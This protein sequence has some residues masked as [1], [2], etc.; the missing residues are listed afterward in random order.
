MPQEVKNIVLAVLWVY[1]QLRVLI[2]LM[3]LFGGLWKTGL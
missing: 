2:I 3:V 1:V